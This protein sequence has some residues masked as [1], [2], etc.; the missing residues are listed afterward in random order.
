MIEI[1]FKTSQGNT[2]WVMCEC[3]SHY[4]EL[5]GYDLDNVLE[6]SKGTGPASQIT[7]PPDWQIIRIRTV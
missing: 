1:T 4:D 3:M 5:N 7:S 6:T 2:Y